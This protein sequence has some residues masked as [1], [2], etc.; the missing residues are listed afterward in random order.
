M[1]WLVVKQYADLLPVNVIDQM[2]LGP[3]R[4]AIGQSLR[5]K[6]GDLG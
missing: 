3:G 4:H 5:L 2:D 1:G 6:L